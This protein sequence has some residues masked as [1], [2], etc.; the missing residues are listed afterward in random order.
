MF[1]LV[2]GYYHWDLINS[3]TGSEDFCCR[4]PL[5]DPHIHNWRNDMILE[6]LNKYDSKWKE[7]IGWVPFFNTS[8]ALFDLRVEF[9]DRA[10]HIDC[11][12]FVYTPTA[13]AALWWDLKS[14]VE[15]YTS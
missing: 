7:Y 10:K 11:T 5:Q 9:H 8:L 3:T 4:L 1:F 13:Y 6:Y 12:H 14:I 2:D 15:N